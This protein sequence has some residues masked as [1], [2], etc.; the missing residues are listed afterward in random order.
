M[1]RQVGSWKI[2]HSYWST[3][4]E[5]RF[6]PQPTYNLTESRPGSELVAETAAA[7]AAASIVFRE[8]DPEYW[9]TLIDHAE[10][11]FKFAT[12]RKEKYHR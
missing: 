8:F 3:P 9:R 2:D 4:D 6:V 5:M 1:L 10:D 12:S 11:L 7:M